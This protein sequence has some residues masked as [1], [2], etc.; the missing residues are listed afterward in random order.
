MDSGIVLDL[1]VFLIFLRNTLGN[2]KLS[3]GMKSGAVC[4]KRA[5]GFWC[6]LFRLGYTKQNQLN[7]HRERGESEE[8][9]VM[10]M[11]CVCR[12]AMQ[13]IW[14]RRLIGSVSVNHRTLGSLPNLACRNRVRL[15]I[16]G[17]KE[18]YAPAL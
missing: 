4:P 7:C 6:G 5:P 2:N 3:S 12:A 10:V 9:H 17:V 13:S 8:E 18:K 11:L 1:G 16:I 15:V 14:A